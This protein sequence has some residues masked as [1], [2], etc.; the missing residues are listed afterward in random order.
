M[1]P[2]SALTHLL[3]FA[4]PALALALGVTLGA[5]FF[6]KKGRQPLRYLHSSLQI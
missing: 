4:A 1:D 3:N 5:H 6:M 2:I